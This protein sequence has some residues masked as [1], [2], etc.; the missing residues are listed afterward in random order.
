MWEN[1][2]WNIIILLIVIIIDEIHLE[3]GQGLFS[4]IWNGWNIIG[5]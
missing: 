2:K 5:Y 3:N 4:T 1:E